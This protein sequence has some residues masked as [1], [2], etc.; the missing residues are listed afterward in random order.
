[1]TVEETVKGTIKLVEPGGAPDPVPAGDS[2][3]GGPRRDAPRDGVRPLPLLGCGVPLLAAAVLLAVL[4]WDVPLVR[5]GVL[6]V[7]TVT[8]LGVVGPLLRRGHALAGESVSL[9][10]LALLVL[11]G[12][13]VGEAVQG[14]PVLPAT[15]GVTPGLALAAILVTIIW[16]G[17]AGLS[18]LR[19]SRS[20]AIL[21]AQAPLPLAVLAI[22]PTWA[23]PALAFFVTAGLDLFLWRATRRHRARLEQLTVGL[24]GLLSGSA[25]LAAA[26]VAALHAV[27]F[28]HAL[29]VSAVLVAGLLVAALW[30]IALSG[31]RARHV[32]GAG[33]MAGVA[34]AAAVVAL[35]APFAVLVPAQW[36]VLGYAGAS[37][38]VLAACPRLLGA[39]RPGCA[40]AGAA[41]LALA[42]LWVLPDV[43]AAVN[44]PLH[45][46]TEPWRGVAGS[47]RADLGP[48]GE[49][50]QGSPAA[51][52]VMALLAVVCLRGCP[53][54]GAVLDDIAP[55]R[56]AVANLG[57]RSDA[58]GT[59]GLPPVGRRYAEIPAAWFTALANVFRRGATKVWQ[60]VPRRHEDGTGS[61]AASSSS[62][63]VLPFA[64]KRSSLPGGERIRA[65][66]AEQRTASAARRAVLI[67]MRVG[68]PVFIALAVVT[69][70]V[71]ARLPYNVTL[72]VLFGL[73]VALLLPAGV[74]QVRSLAVHR[75]VVATG[76]GA[77]V[78]VCAWSLAERVA[79]LP[80][81][82]AVF[83]L[84][85][86]CALLARTA[87]AQVV[88]G[89]GGMLT[90]GGLT[91][92]AAVLLGWPAL[93]GAL[94]V[95]T[96]RALSLA[97]IRLPRRLRVATAR[98]HAPLPAVPV[99]R[100]WQ[101][102][103]LEVAAVVVSYAALA[104]PGLS[105][106]DV[107]LV[108]ALIAV[109]A[110]LGVR[111]RTGGWRAVAVVE[112][113]VLAALA[114]LLLG[115]SFAAAVHGPFDWLARPWSGVPASARAALSPEG[116]WPVEPALLPVLALA[117]VAVTVVAGAVLGRRAAISAGLVV[118]SLPAAVL[119]LALGLS[120]WAAL[121]CLL[122]LTAGLAA[123]AAVGPVG[124]PVGGRGVLAALERAAPL[125][126]ALWTAS[127]AAAWSLASAPATA[128]VLAVLAVIAA[129]Y[130][131]EVRTS[132]TRG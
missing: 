82:A 10:G 104:L 130:A 118:F 69:T 27:T 20:L 114:P 28:W 30:A 81:L 94:A 5:A 95:L 72:A 6:A 47:V 34:G 9:A 66:H 53:L 42:G 39:L 11:T 102:V 98:I 32:M 31:G 100:T 51:P 109:L 8:A 99:A 89:A 13:S 57:A 112:A 76:A 110:A 124:D 119:P 60:G 3:D 125:P 84:F 85:V 79:T 56:R 23:G 36:R 78:L 67:L 115:T 74:V 40:A 80:M 43:I 93:A 62:V 58:P 121:A 73:A 41:I 55:L 70:P 35:A 91:A 71:A 108:T 17:Y 44:L 16:M 22:L 83:T 26:V 2:P 128:T 129:G 86:V 25:G 48:G 101:W 116:P 65:R 4:A 120:Y 111:N 77:A 126:A 21:L 14:R 46:A 18:S 49:V 54:A 117:A 131:L 122:A 127:L 45:W 92:C 50:W 37:C 33:F 97:P 106:P 96:V 38:L 19:L 87:A 52:L 103:A 75:A 7:F 123:C 113:C 88:T 24:G 59:P 1:M 107:A 12:L 63:I 68:V 90:A 61:Q 105:R 64:V 132:R 15:G 29:R